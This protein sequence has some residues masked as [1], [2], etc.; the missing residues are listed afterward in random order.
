MSE[1]P[2]ILFDGCCNLCNG[3]VRFVLR[4]SVEGTFNFIPSQSEEGEQLLKAVGIERDQ[5]ETL[6]F[7]KQDKVHEKSD[8][9]LEI[10]RHLSGLWKFFVIFKIIPKPLRDKPYNLIAKKRYKWFGAS[11]NCQISMNK[12]Q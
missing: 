1:K 12:S 8:A 11:D 9:T 5:M 2:I 4:H 6:I 7:I 3:A 10:C